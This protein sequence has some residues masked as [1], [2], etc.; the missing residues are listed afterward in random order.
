MVEPDGCGYEHNSGLL[1]PPRV[2][3]TL[4][5]PSYRLTP[6]G[7]RNRMERHR[8]ATTAR[9]AA[10][11]TACGLFP[12][13]RL[14]F[15]RRHDRVRLDVAVTLAKGQRRLDDDGLIGALKS[16]VDALQ[17]PVLWNDQQL[18]WGAISWERAAGL[19]GTV[20]LTLTR[21]D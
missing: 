7:T 20:R 8:L 13:A 10:Y 21:Q 15:F 9:S 1:A 17:G 12:G 2:W 14:P 4:P 3:L 6:N 16:T 19:A 5:L 11:L 18:T